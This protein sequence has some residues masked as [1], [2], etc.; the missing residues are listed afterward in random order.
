MVRPRRMPAL[1]QGDV[2]TAFD[3]KPIKGT[4]DLAL[5][6]AGTPK[7]KPASL[8]VWRDQQRH[9]LDVTSGSEQKQ[10]VASAQAGSANP[11]PV[12]MALMPMTADA[13]GQLNLDPGVK[14]VVVANVA[15]G[16]PA[17]QSGIQAGD[18]IERVAGKPVS[19]PADV[20]A[21][22]R[23][24]EQQKKQAIPLLVIRDGATSYLGLQ[25]TAG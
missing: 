11:N 19:S 17:D 9:S 24:A 25:L 18:V 12:G 6:V 16:S 21:A 5:D 22:V 4:R 3:G 8:T 7:G 10:Q 13:R 15:E 23:A 20:A 1:Q 2:I 14:G